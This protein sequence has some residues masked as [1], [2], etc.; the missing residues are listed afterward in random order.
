MKAIRLTLL[1]FAVSILCG[2]YGMAHYQKAPPEALSHGTGSAPVKPDQFEVKPDLYPKY[3][4]R[5]GFKPPPRH[6]D[7]LQFVMVE[8]H[9]EDEW[10]VS[11]V[12]GNRYVIQSPQYNERQ[13]RYLNSLS[14]GSG[15]LVNI[16]GRCLRWHDYGIYITSTGKI[17]G[18]WEFLPSDRIGGA[19][20]YMHMSWSPEKNSGWPAD[21][22]FIPD[23]RKK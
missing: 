4:A 21:E 7:L 20:R 6:P 3:R 5:L 2:C 9:G 14:A 16:F 15:R 19:N 23:T 10:H 8:I 13:C 12:I 11:H 17:D 22:M 18:G 1:T